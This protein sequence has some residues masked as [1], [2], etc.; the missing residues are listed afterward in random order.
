MTDH[1][2]VDGADWRPIEEIAALG[3]GTWLTTG[4]VPP[5]QGGLAMYAEWVTL[6]AVL[7]HTEQG[8]R[9]WVGDALNEMERL[10]GADQMLQAVAMAELKPKTA[11]QYKR[12]AR[13]VRRADRR[14]A[15]EWSHHL[16]V[17]PLD[18]PEQRLW[19]DRAEAEE[20]S[21]AELRA[22]LQEAKKVD[23][24]PQLDFS[25]PPPPVWVTCPHCHEQFDLTTEDDYE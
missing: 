17:A 19:L 24:P 4:W 21:V 3:P 12:V 22:A 16:Q 18:P 11:Q 9:W 7:D 2:Q 23:E 20:W 14:A 5:E 1:E 13:Q 6:L 8:V 15:L 10:L 25:D